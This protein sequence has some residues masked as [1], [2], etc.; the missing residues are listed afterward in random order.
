MIP[1]LWAGMLGTGL[2]MAQDSGPTEFVVK[3]SVARPAEK[4]PPIGVNNFGG[5][6]AVDYGANNF[7]RSSGNEPIYWRNLHRVLECGENW[8]TLDGP[9]TSWFQLWGNGFLSGADVRIYRLVDKEGKPLPLKGDYLDLATADH[10]IPVGTSKILPPGSPGLPQG[11][12]V[13]SKYCTP[14]TLA[15]IRHG[16]V[17]VSDSRYLENGQSYY[18]SVVAVAPGGAESDLSN[19]VSATP[20]A[21]APFAPQIVIGDEDKPLNVAAGK[22]FSWT[23]KVLLGKAPYTWS[24]VDDAG[25]DSTLPEGL[26]INA[27]TGAISGSAV[28]KPE[29]FRF[30]L[31]VTDSEGQSDSRSSILNPKPLEGASADKAKP[32]PPSDVKAV[33]FNGAVRLTWKASPSANVDGYRI[34]RSTVPLAQQEEKVY[35]APGAPK[36]EKFDYVVVHQRWENFDMKLVN[37]R[38][39]GIG[40]P[41]DV[42]NWYWRVDGGAAKFS[43][44]PHGNVPKEMFD[45]GET[46]LQI[47]AESGPVTL[48]QLVFIGTDKGRE[49]LWYG[50]FEPGM[51]YRFEGWMKQQGLGDEGKVKLNY[52]KDAYP[53]IEQ[54]F[55]VGSEWKK[56]TYEFQAPAGRPEKAWH[57][58]HQLNFTGPGKLWVDNLRLFRCDTPDE[59]DK[60]YTP[61]KTVL[62]ELLASQPAQG[63]KGSHRTWYLSR[64]AEMSSILSMHANSQ[65]SPDWSTSTST[66]MEITLPMGLMFDEKTGVSPQ[67]RVVPWLVLQHIHHSEQDWQ[68]FIEYLGA[69]YDPA[70]DS[71]EKKPWAYRRY[72]QRGNPQTWADTFREIIVE[73]GNETWHN[74]VFP[75]WVGFARQNQVTQGGREYGFFCRY[76]IDTM[77]KSPYWESAKLGQKIKFQL[78]AFYNGKVDANGVVSGYGEEAMKV[79]PDGTLLGHANYVG[80]K[81][82]TGDKANTTY[83]DDGI[84]KTL[85]GFVLGAEPGMKDWFAA[86]NAL[87]TT[88]HE[89]DLAAYEGGPSGY[90]LPGQGTPEMVETNEKY[91]KS[92][93]MGVAALDAWLHS[94]RYGYTFQNF[95]GYGQ[96]THWN[97]HTVLKDGF[98][99]TPGWLA[100]VLRNRLAPGDLLDVEVKNNPVQ[101]IGTKD[102]R[103]TDAFAFHEGK[104][105]SVITYSRK[106]EGEIP[107]TITL[108]IKSVKKIS[109]HK[110]TGDP[111]LTNREALNVQIQS[112]ELDAALF[113]D[114]KLVINDKS[115]ASAGG[116]TPGSIF[117]YVFETN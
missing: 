95:L 89:Y 80:P 37:D 111:R 46:C 35:L 36:L 33:A 84:R 19:E 86:R 4:V 63:A 25:K 44:V 22:A 27:G 58:G 92:L 48:N 11:G 31:K 64:H 104:T 50:Q 6:G 103:M 106:L 112:Q 91:G 40:N 53:G 57:F 113:V 71:P 28:A 85:A 45:P 10:V 47:Q 116:I 88:A 70:K 110:L 55:A 101:K 38:V 9:G 81:W 5:M 2:L 15:S 20:N 78:G 30:I 3:D 99:P 83:Q 7:I 43:L 65:I 79:C 107:A 61:N 69:P 77:K 12:W 97:S 74:G 109:V 8:F 24:V 72:Q 105:W 87:S 26:Q 17:G 73:F 66:T 41:L 49:A 54:T 102:C 34:K 32:A 60:I 29:A 52:G 56:F 51:N 39:R 82:E 21:K 62:N 93:A 75:D 114:G 59:A 90:A 68:N 100:M 115:G 42:P 96:G 1:I 23:S 18:Y 108:P 98:R 76:L 67:E 16:N 13:A 117:C 14:F 94:Y